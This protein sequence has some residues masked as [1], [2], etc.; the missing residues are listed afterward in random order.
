MKREELEQLLI[1]K[2]YGEISAADGKRLD[3]WLAEHPED[4]AE[5]AELH[6]TASLLN[7]IVDVS[8]SKEPI[9]LPNPLE[10]QIQ[11]KVY[12]VW[13]Y[14]AA[15]VV[16]FFVVGFW[17]GF[18]IEAVGVRMAIGPAAS[19]H[20]PVDPKTAKYLQDMIQTVSSVNSTNEKLLLRQQE[21]E[22]DVALLKTVEVAGQKMTDMKLQKFSDE[23][24]RQINTKLGSYQSRSTLPANYSPQDF[25]TEDNPKLQS[26]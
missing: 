11:K 24:V 23:L 3:S 9:R 2:L 25:Q 7:Q 5:F 15:A 1:E 21:M 10:I 18:S 26:Y 20:S 6:K 13:K 8:A 16:L 14:A 19:T 12:P 17:R 4:Q 22:N